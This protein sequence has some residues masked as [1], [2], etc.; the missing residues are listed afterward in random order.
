LMTAERPARPPPIT[1]I[2]GVDAI[3]E[4]TAFREL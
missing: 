1:M 2:F 4:C 3:F